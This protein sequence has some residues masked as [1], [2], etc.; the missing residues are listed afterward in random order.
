L[1]IRST[2]SAPSALVRPVEDT[3]SSTACTDVKEASCGRLFLV[4]WRDGHG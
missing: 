3:L 2:G 4:P 1:L